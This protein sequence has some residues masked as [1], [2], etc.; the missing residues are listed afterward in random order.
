MGFFVES[1]VILKLTRTL[2]SSNHIF[3]AFSTRSPRSLTNAEVLPNTGEIMRDSIE[4]SMW[5]AM[6][7]SGSAFL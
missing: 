1:E 4:E 7:L 2:P 6:G 5:D 3:L